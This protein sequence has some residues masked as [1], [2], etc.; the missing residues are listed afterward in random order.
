MDTTVFQLGGRQA[1]E[2]R[3]LCSDI[4][5]QHVPGTLLSVSAHLPTHLQVRVR[6]ADPDS[7]SISLIN[8]L[9]YLN[10]CF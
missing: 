3:Q 8:T 6:V 10:I 1:P 5:Y 4:R 9:I 7:G 2:E